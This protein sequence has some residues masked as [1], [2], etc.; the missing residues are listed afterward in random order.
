MNFVSNCWRRSVRAAAMTLWLTA[1]ACGAGWAQGLVVQ[2]LRDESSAEPDVDLPWLDV[3]FRSR[4]EN[5]TPTY[6]GNRAE[7]VLRHSWS[8]AM[9]SELAALSTPR[10]ERDL[11]W[12]LTLQV[13]DPA[14]RG[15]D[16]SVDHRLSGILGAG[17]EQTGLGTAAAHLPG[18]EIWVF[19]AF[20]PQP[21]RLQGLSTPSADIDSVDDVNRVYVEHSGR[22]TVGRYEGTQ[23]FLFFL[24]PSRA[25]VIES[26]SFLP[27]FEAYG[28]LQ[29][30]RPTSDLDLAFANPGA[31]AP[32]LDDLGQFVT[33]R[34]DYAAAPVPEPATA[35]LLAAGLL[36]T[37]RHGR[38]RQ[39]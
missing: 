26:G 3:Q 4:V 23:S 8:F 6:D 19:E 5:G 22:A 34:V 9:R 16:L 39:A 33:F 11:G 24:Q 36:F 12:S 28:W 1:G 27:T 13:L 30:G 29:F 35:A 2:D 20:A 25:A 21:R 38:R 37:L 18:F 14:R 15:Y 17:L 10:I 31:G 32:P 7:V